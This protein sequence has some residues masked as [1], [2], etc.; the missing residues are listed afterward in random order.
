MGSDIFTESAVAIEVVDFL[1]QAPIK[2]KAVRTNIANI[3]FKEDYI[4]EQARDAMIKN[5]D[6]FIETF[7]AEL[8]MDDSEYSSGYENDRDRNDFMIRTFCEN[9]DI[10]L[11]K[12][13]DWSLRI[14][15]SNRES[16]YDILTDV[17]YIMFEPY[18][19]FAT[20]MT[21]KGKEVAEALGT[22][23]IHETTWTVHSY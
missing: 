1:R 4:D 14:F 22:D 15:D 21:D 2:K 8:S 5:R 9:V 16:G 17:L 11:E 3:L 20:V 13:P 19:L 6:G 18:D 23:L 10:D 12:L 7:T